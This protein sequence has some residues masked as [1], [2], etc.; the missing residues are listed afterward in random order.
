MSPGKVNSDSFGRVVLLGWLAVVAV[1]ISAAV[2]IQFSRSQA[3]A[4]SGDGWTVRP[5]T[6]TPATRPTD[7]TFSVAYWNIASARTGEDKIAAAI[8]AFDIVG[9]SEVRGQDQLQN[10]A[11]L[12]N[13]NGLFAPTEL[14]GFDAHFGNAVLGKLPVDYWQRVPL[15]PGPRASHFRNVV[16]TRVD[17]SP[18]NSVTVLTTHIDRTIDRVAQLRSV[19]KLFDSLAP[20][21]VLMG[22]FNTTRDDALLNAAIADGIT[23]DPH[24]GQAVTKWTDSNRIDWML[25]KGLTVVE[26]GLHDQGESDHPMIWARLAIAG[27][28]SR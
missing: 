22:D 5:A 16:L 24:R 6:F 11:S 15:K 14:Q 12:T 27:S 8:A 13:S 4:D 2:L 18:G 23:I 1:A 28:V 26:S 10:L 3:P 21:A 9:L 19:L 17:V 7:K 25:V 20:P